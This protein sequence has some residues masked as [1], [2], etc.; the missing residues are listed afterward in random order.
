MNRWFDCVFDFQQLVCLQ[1]NIVFKFVDVMVPLLHLLVEDVD[2]FVQVVNQLS[3]LSDYR[4]RLVLWR[5]GNH[6]AL[7]SCWQVR[8][9]LVD[10]LPLKGRIAFD[11]V[12]F[13][14]RSLGVL[15]LNVL[16]I[17]R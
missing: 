4:D 8:R 3:L 5:K 11:A 16:R 17:D 1:S 6:Q 7:L 15:D 12:I 10:D 14:L 9:D 13:A 2:S